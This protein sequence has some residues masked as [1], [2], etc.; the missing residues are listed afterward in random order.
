MGYLDM[1][2]PEDKET[3]STVNAWMPY[4]MLIDKGEVIDV[5][6]NGQSIKEYTDLA[7]LKEQ[8]LDSMKINKTQII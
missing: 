8:L 6:I 4:E 2:P 5:F 1:N 7:D 3:Q